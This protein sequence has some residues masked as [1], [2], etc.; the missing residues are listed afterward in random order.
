[1]DFKIRVV[2]DQGTFQKAFSIREKVFIQE[3]DVPESI[4]RDQFDK[5]SVHL[6]C[7]HEG[8]PIATGRFFI[9]EKR[10][11]IGRVAV[12]KEY[13]GKGVGRSITEK[14]VEM[15]LEKGAEEVYAHVQLHASSFYEKCGFKARGDIFQEADIDHVLMVYRR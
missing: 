9:E 3:Q 14:L 6:I 15:S 2:K 13:R 1:M 8:K 7:Y 12:L 10:S 11:K 5:R 4:E